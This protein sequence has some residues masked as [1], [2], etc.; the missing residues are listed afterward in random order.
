[1]ITNS[2]NLR[3]SEE[4]FAEKYEWQGTLTSFDTLALD[5]NSFCFNLKKFKVGFNLK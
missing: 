3:S 1:M 2:F 5:N 4:H